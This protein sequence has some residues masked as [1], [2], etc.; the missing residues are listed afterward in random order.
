MC[1][2]P[3][4][5]RDSVF[6]WSWLGCMALDN[7]Y[8]PWN[9]KGNRNACVYW[10]SMADS[11]FASAGCDE[12]TCNDVDNGDSFYFML[13]ELEDPNKVRTP[14]FRSCFLLLQLLLMTIVLCILCD[15]NVN[16]GVHQRA[17]A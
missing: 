17:Q 5:D 10:P 4:L 11:G 13:P 3:L 1:A 16:I 12:A 7:L 6:A 14:P 2:P 9:T 8:K 15:H